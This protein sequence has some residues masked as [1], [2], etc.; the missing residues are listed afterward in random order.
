[1]KLGNKLFDVPF[2][3]A[4]KLKDGA[5]SLGGKIIHSAIKSQVIDPII[6]R[7]TNPKSILEK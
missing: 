3:L 1:M 6:D 7:I 5:I 2:I 4:N